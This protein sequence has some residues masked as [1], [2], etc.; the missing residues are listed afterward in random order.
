MFDNKM[1]GA[2]IFLPEFYRGNIG[3]EHG[4]ANVVLP[5]LN[6]TQLEMIGRVTFSYQLIHPFNSRLTSLSQ[7]GT[8]WKSLVCDAD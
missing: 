5:V 4:G 6:P 1:I 2:A 3:G 8:Y 7:I